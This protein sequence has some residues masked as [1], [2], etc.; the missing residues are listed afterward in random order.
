[1]IAEKTRLISSREKSHIA[2]FLD[3]AAY[4]ARHT[5]MDEKQLFPGFRGFIAEETKGHEPISVEAIL[6]NEKYDDFLV[7]SS[8]LNLFSRTSTLDMLEY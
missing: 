4:E 7:P 3:M 1:M 5:F 2:E 8:M 6:V